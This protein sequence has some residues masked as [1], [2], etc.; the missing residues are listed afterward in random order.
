MHEG[1]RERRGSG[2]IKNSVT[3][4]ELPITGIRGDKGDERREGVERKEDEKQE[5]EGVHRWRRR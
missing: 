4:Q 5:K 2:G 3:L 1:E